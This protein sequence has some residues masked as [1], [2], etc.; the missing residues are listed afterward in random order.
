MKKI[1]SV[2][3]A[4]LFVLSAVPVLAQEQTTDIVTVNESAGITPDSPIYG[5]KIALDRIRL[6]LT[7]NRTEK[8]ELGL[9]MAEQRLIEAQLM[10]DKGDYKALEIARNEHGRFLGIAKKQIEMINDD[11]EKALEL[12]AKLEESLEQQQ[13]RINSI[14]LLIQN[15]TPEQTERLKALLEEF[16]NETEDVKIKLLEKKDFSRIKLKAKLNL[17]DDEAEKRIDEI[18]NKTIQNIDKIAGQQI[19]QAEKMLDLVSTQI[20]KAKE[21]N[22]TIKDIAL[23]LKDKAQSKLDEAKTALQNKEYKL[24]IA[25]ARESKKLSALAIASVHGLTEENKIEDL[26][27]RAENQ[28]E[29]IKEKL[30]K[31]KKTRKNSSEED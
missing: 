11:P 21:Q 24:T 16:R 28:A 18:Q 19:E 12:E 14:T 7:F 8:T 2:L 26:I 15:L 31:V 29:K 6:S 17:S 27:K 22:F 5:L 25:L 20:E 30:E 13:E 3:V 9:K 23:T 1:L 4:L 10:A